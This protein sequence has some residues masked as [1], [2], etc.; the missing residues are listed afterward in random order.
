MTEFADGM[1]VFKRIQHC[2]TQSM[3]T[4]NF[5]PIENTKQLTHD[6]R[7]ACRLQVL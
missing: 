4:R 5:S 7:G 3:L 1:L 2:K 6:T